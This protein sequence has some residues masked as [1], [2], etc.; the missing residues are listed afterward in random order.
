MSEFWMFEWDDMSPETPSNVSERGGVVR[1]G[2]AVVVVMVRAAILTAL[3]AYC[4]FFLVFF[5]LI[6]K[7]TDVITP[8]DWMPGGRPY[9]VVDI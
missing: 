1:V 4:G 7:K 5:C 8:C 3:R 2:Q 9:G 6:M